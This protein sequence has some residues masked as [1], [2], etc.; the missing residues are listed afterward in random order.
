MGFNKH[1][2]WLLKTLDVNNIDI[3]Q[4]YCHCWGMGN[5]IDPPRLGF[6]GAISIKQNMKLH[7]NQNILSISRHWEKSVSVKR[8]TNGFGI[9][10]N[11]CWIFPQ[12]WQS[13]G[14]VRLPGCTYMS[15]SV[16][17][18]TLPPTLCL[19]IPYGNW[20]I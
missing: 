12:L 17:W 8:I 4:P 16:M 14:P 6:R 7:S 19:A 18:G 20:I 5:P 3:I 11:Q 2:N 9:T 1:K 13:K 15:L 10:Q